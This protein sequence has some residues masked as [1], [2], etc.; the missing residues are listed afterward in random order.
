[1]KKIMKKST[2][3]VLTLALVLSLCVGLGPIESHAENTGRTKVIV[4]TAETVTVGNIAENGVTNANITSSTE[5]SYDT[6]GTF[7]NPLYKPVWPD[8]TSVLFTLTYN[9]YAFVLKFAEPIK[10]SEYSSMEINMFMCA[11]TAPDVPITTYVYESG[12]GDLSTS[13]AKDVFTTKDNC[14]VQQTWKLDLTKYADKDGEVKNLTFL[15]STESTAASYY[16]F[17][18]FRLA[19]A[20]KKLTFSDWDIVDGNYDIGRVYSLADKGID[21]LDGYAFEGIVNYNGVKN[22]DDAFFR[23][24]GNAGVSGN[25]YVALHWWA[26]DDSTINMVN[27]YNSENQGTYALSNWTSSGNVTLRLTFD[28]TATDTWTIGIWLNGSYK[29]E[30]NLTNTQL[31][32]ELLMNGITVHDYGK[33]TYKELTFS[34]WGIVDGAYVAGAYYLQDT[35]ITSLDGYA[36]EGI[37]NFNGATDETE[38]IRIGGGDNPFAGVQIW[39]N[40]TVQLKFYNHVN[41]GTEGE[42]A[43]TPAG[44]SNN[45]DMTI[46][47]T[48]D[49]TATNTW[50]MGV[51]VN[52][53][54][55]GD[56]ALINSALGTSLLFWNTGITIKDA[57]EETEQTSPTLTFSDWGIRDGDYS[58]GRSFILQDSRITSLD[59]YAFEGIVNFN[60]ATTGG[61]TLRIGCNPATPED[62]IAP[63]KGLTFWAEGTTKLCVHNF[64]NDGDGTSTFTPEGWSNTGNMKLRLTFDETAKDA[65]TIGIWVNDSFLGE[66]KLTSTALG[67][68][69]LYGTETNQVLYFESIGEGVVTKAEISYDNYLSPI[70]EGDTVYD[71][72]VMPLA[73]ADG[74]ID[75]IML[76]YDIDEIVSVKSANL[77]VTYE[78]G[79]DYTVE[80]G[81]L[82]IPSGSKIPISAYGDYYF[83]T[84]T[85][86]AF[87]CTKGGYIY[88]S[89]GS[90]FHERQIVVTYKHSDT[91][92]GSVPEKQGASLTNIIGKLSNKEP[93][94]IV[95]YGDS[96]TVG[97]NASSFIGAPPYL[98]T[99]AELVTKTL[100]EKYEYDDISY[101]NT[102]LGGQLT[103]WGVANAQT[104]AADKSP[105]LMVLAFGMNDI[106]TEPATYQSQIEQIINT[107]RASNPDC[108]IILVGTMLPNEEAAGAYGN[109]IQFITNLN[110]VAEKYDNVAV[111]DM[112]TMHKKLLERKSYRDM[113]GNNVNHPNDFLGRVYAQVVLETLEM[114]EYKEMTFAD[115]G[116]YNANASI[117][118]WDV[119]ALSDSNKISTLDGVAISGKVNFNGLT[120]GENRIL[121]GGTDT[122]PHGGFALFSDGTQLNLA[123]LSIGADGNAV[124]IPAEDWTALANKAFTLR[125]TFDQEETGWTVKVYADGKLESTSTFAGVEPG[126]YIANKPEI[127]IKRGNYTELTFSD[128]G[129]DMGVLNGNKTYALTDDTLIDTLDGVA[130]SGDVN[131]NGTAKY[132]NIGGTATLRHAGFWFF[133]T[134]SELQISPQGIGGPAAVATVINASEWAT[135][136]N[137]EFT[138]RV[139]FDKNG[140]SW[141]VGVY[142]NGVEKLKQSFADVEPGL[143]MGI[144]P[145]ITVER[146]VTLPEK[147]NVKYFVDTLDN[148]KWLGR[149]GVVDA[150]VTADATA[151]GFEANVIANGSVVLD[152]AVMA[153]T[154]FAVYIDGVR[155]A[156]AVKIT[157]TQRRVEI[158]SFSDGKEHHIRVVKQTEANGGL[159]TMISLTFDGSFGTKPANK[160]MYIEIMGDS[161][162]AGGGNLIVDGQEGTVI[163]D[164]D[165]TLAFPFLTAEN[166]DADVSVVSCS[167]IGASAHPDTHWFIE[168]DFY[169][170]ASFFRD[171]NVYYEFERVPDVVVINLG[172][173]DVMAYAVDKD[174]FIPAAKELVQLVREKYNEDVKIIW[175]DNMMGYTVKDWV[176]EAFEDLG[177]EQEGLYLLQFEPN[178]AGGYKHPTKEAHEASAETLTDYIRGLME[179]KVLTFSDWG[180]VDGNYSQG[181]VYTLKDTNITS[182]DGYAFEGVVNFNGSTD[183]ANYM[184]I[185]GAD[186]ANY[187]LQVWANGDTQ[188]KLFSF[189]NTED[190]EAVFEPSDW[191]NSGNMTLRLTFD[192]KKTD[193]WKVGV[194]VNGS[195]VGDMNLTNTA[196][197][198]KLLFVG[199]Q[200]TIY[201]NDGVDLKASVDAGGYVVRFAGTSIDGKVYEVG[202]IFNE[203]GVHTI[204]YTENGDAVERSL[205]IYLEGDANGDG[206][207]NVKDLVR[208]KLYICGRKDIDKLGKEGTDLDQNGKLEDDDIALLR[209]KLIND[210]ATDIE[211]KDVLHYGL[212]EP[213]YNLSSGLTNSYSTSDFIVETVGAFGVDTFRIWIPSMASAIADGKGGYTVV[214]DPNLLAKLQELVEG[215]QEQ[216]VTQIV[217]CPG[218]HVIM[219]DY[220]NY[221]YSDGKAYSAKQIENGETEGLTA[222]Y[223]DYLLV[224]NPTTEADKYKTFMQVQQ[225]Y[226]ELLAKNVPGITHF[227][228]INEP[229]GNASV[230]PLGLLCDASN[231]TQPEAYSTETI[232]KICMDYCRAATI[233]L[234]LAGRMEAKVLAPALSGDG[235]AKTMLTACYDY[236][237][238]QTKNDADEYFQI[239]N[240]HPY[241]Y[242]TEYDGAV[243]SNAGNWAETYWKNAWVQF[244][245]DM[246]QIAVNAG[247]G[248]TPVWFTEIGVT[249][250]GDKKTWNSPAGGKVT[251]TMAAERMMRLLELTKDLEFVDAIIVF[252]L[253]DMYHNGSFYG[254]DYEANFGMLEY[255]DNVS[256]GEASL[257]EIGKR[258]YQL[259][260]DGSTD[261][262]NLYAV[263]KKY[264]DAYK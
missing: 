64:I 108:D 230:H 91:W 184:K 114:T 27:W 43:Y 38:N 55:Q 192:E 113:T 72:S 78:S 105:D 62:S 177:G 69:I 44:W 115:W 256:S 189:I 247:D 157:P 95:F 20:H 175:T 80:N 251:Q 106:Q 261:Y 202:D 120:G 191:S 226:Y 24:G 213:S 98:E 162:T 160:E 241:I 161:I 14:N 125:I 188:L 249:D 198:T 242:Y 166:L 257:K 87:A 76:A 220:P 46:R 165:G 58:G 236:I 203:I 208:A 172:T 32:T 47:L 145:E 5:V 262:S 12:A 118:G 240:W 233:G 180:I 90:Y 231:W 150:G 137:Q 186:D 11:Y 248:D 88:F 228:T 216:G 29:G 60:G 131:F 200:M 217:V 109:Q 253:N 83:N 246:Y 224:P 89:E 99:Y 79:K 168:R 163:P 65:W 235:R 23:I 45:L 52:G 53:T 102:A 70:W 17:G 259:L 139:T 7:L 122:T 143:Y 56:V 127:T 205:I 141:I 57:T 13:K 93:V 50:T 144:A 21:S 36:F 245:K 119:Y 96:I 2:A 59:G 22:S 31:G 195:H 147:E 85:D 42:I 129:I 101:I 258:Y 149:T 19:G 176:L 121:F 92:S 164:Y 77:A 74:T 148:I 183:G 3:I 63:F 260:N 100:K 123:P 86:N 229:E 199:T 182:L 84:L 135:L 66:K 124:A 263:L 214:L 167:G 171:E 134:G 104:L 207:V 26:H 181:V 156:E 250:L 28:E 254:D 68:Q 18:A 71:E 159:C 49:E 97:A 128:W 237:A 35:S 6:G 190:G 10:V 223:W 116:T 138:L 173:N 238:K 204:S 243:V 112:T 221:I 136:S 239:L 170:R 67:T 215:L 4:P 234:R 146:T 185:G 73:N 210:D 142:V 82:V 244:Q 153:D 178:I 197:G 222:V 37:V 174:T 41:G 218:S 1:M 193:T 209:S 40:G 107:V 48:F 15:S 232:A 140:T 16:T 110:A 187:A 61:T 194:W 201:D 126:L 212:G 179:Y 151:T 111:A 33:T 39:P 252:R 211:T 8:V 264:Y 255:F 152:A 54:H 103:E 94:N 196:L 154:Y 30:M 206:V 227:E 81:K 225:D 219:N 169:T 130:I 25:S 155:Q 133:S 132:I 34:D 117:Y 51:W 75:P 158:A 9:N